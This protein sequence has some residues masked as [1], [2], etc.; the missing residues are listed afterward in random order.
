MA[1]YREFPTAEE[2]DNLQ[3][4]WNPG[5]VLHLASVSEVD[6]LCKLLNN[7]DQFRNA[8]KPPTDESINEEWAIECSTAYAILDEV[9]D[10]LQEAWAEIDGIN[11]ET[12]KDLKRLLQDFD[13][14]A[15]TRVLIQELV[16]PR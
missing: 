3:G 13:A 8:I 10:Q 9:R 12:Y 11:G 2:L 1:N 6:P 5:R 15:R 16:D 7:L 4:E 14:I